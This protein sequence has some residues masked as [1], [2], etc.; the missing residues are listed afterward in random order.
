VTIY[1][2]DSSALVKRYVAEKGSVWFHPLSPLPSQITLVVSRITWVE[3]CSS[4]ARL[5]RENRLSPADLAAVLDSFQRDWDNQY[6]VIELDDSLARSAADLLFRHSL[7][8]FD[9]IQLASCLRLK[10]AA[11]ALASDAVTFVA[12]DDR[13]IAAAVAEQVVIVNPANLEGA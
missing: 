9:A 4:L 11:A 6:Q 2:L 1:F 13:L 12:S 3:V 8:A 7:R 10:R 5:A